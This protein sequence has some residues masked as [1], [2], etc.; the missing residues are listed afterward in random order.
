MPSASVTTINRM[1]IARRIPQRRLIF[2][3]AHIK[4][5]RTAI[6]R[7]QMTEALDGLGDFGIADDGIELFVEVMGEQ[8]IG[9]GAVCID[10]I[11]NKRF[12]RFVP[13]D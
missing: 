11:R 12:S 6:A 3:D 5:C 7:V 1:L 10:F 8:I 2:S 9:Q 13:F 4:V